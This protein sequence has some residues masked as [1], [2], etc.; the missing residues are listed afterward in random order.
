MNLRDYLAR[1][2]WCGH[3]RDPPTYIH[4]ILFGWMDGA[5]TDPDNY[6]VLPAKINPQPEKT[7]ESDAAPGAAFLFTIQP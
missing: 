6:I 2:E 3:D 1:E 4:G 7:E 5:C